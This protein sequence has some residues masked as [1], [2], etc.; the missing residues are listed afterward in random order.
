M[1]EQWDDYQIRS[2]CIGG[3]KPFFQLLK[4]YGIENESPNVKYGHPG[5]RWYKKVHASKLD[6]SNQEIPKP[7]K[8]WNERKSLTI[9]Q[10]KI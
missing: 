1:K 3:N 2:I 9:E 10:L 5:V 7:P 6:G 4:E 8:D